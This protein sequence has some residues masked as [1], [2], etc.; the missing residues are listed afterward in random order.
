M[1]ASAVRSPPSSTYRVLAVVAV[2]HAALIVLIW[3]G[4]FYFDLAVVSSR[5]WMV[6]SWL[7]LIWPLVLLLHPD[8]SPLRIL[9]PCLIGIAMLAPCLSTL[10]SFTIWAIGGFAS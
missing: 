9:V 10:W 6:F 2:F 4:A 1:L 3:L 5:A 8:R 7:W